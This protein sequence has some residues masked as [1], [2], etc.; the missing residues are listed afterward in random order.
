MN[1]GFAHLHPPTFPIFGGSERFDTGASFKVNQRRCDQLWNC[2]GCLLSCCLLG[3]GTTLVKRHLQ[4]R[5]MNQPIPADFSATK[6]QSQTLQARKKMRV[7]TQFPET[8][9]KKRCVSRRFMDS[10]TFWRYVQLTLQL[11]LPHYLRFSF[12]PE[13]NKT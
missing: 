8:L 2:H 12:P 9:R 11:S 13:R 1:F 6:N 10:P 3:R 5:P 4:C 7:S